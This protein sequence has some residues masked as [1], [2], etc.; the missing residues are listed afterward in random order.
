MFDF[1]IFIMTISIIVFVHES[2]HFMA[3]RFFGVKVD[4]FAIGFGKKLFVKKLGLTEFSIR[5]IPLGGFV[6]F[7]QSK[8]SNDS[9]LF[10]NQ[11]LYKKFIIVAAG[12][13]INFIFGRR[14]SDPLSGFFL[15]KKISYL[16]IK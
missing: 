1:L 4:D 12:P 15:C 14:V 6:R 13:L 3:A 2:G 16:I 11:S 8:E 7:T 9:L 10:E 5:A